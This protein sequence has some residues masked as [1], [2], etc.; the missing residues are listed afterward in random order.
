M[1][2]HNCLAATR[3]VELLDQRDTTDITHGARIGLKREV[4]RDTGA[5][6]PL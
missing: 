3:I 1:V 4:R 6:P 5:V 2:P